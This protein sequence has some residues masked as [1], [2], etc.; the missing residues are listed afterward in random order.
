MT[1]FFNIFTLEQDTQCNPKLMVEKLKLWYGKKRIPKSYDTKIKPI[2]N[3]FGDSFL[4]N[5]EPFF[6]DTKTDIAYKSQYLQL[7]GRRAYGDY[8]LYGTTYLDLSL[9]EDVDQDKLKTNPLLT[10]KQNKIYFKH[11]DI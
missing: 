11:E 10:I 4:L 9:F 3:L 1:L 8:K 5:P 7:A 2:G 6:S